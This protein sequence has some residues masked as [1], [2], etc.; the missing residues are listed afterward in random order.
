M[1][2]ILLQRRADFQELR[3][4]HPI[5][6]YKG[7]EIQQSQESLSVVYDFRIVPDIRFTPRVTITQK[8]HALTE[9]QLHNLVF[10]LGMIESISYWKSTC[11]P[12]YL[13]SA[14]ALSDEQVRWWTQL[15]RLGLGEFFYRNDL[16]EEMRGEDLIT[17]S[18]LGTAF[19]RVSEYEV[20]SD[21]ILVGGGKDSALLLALFDKYKNELQRPITPFMLNP[22]PAAKQCTALC[23]FAARAVFATRNI[24]P[25]LL[26]LNKRGYLNGHT[27]FSA[28]LAFLST[29]VASVNKAQYVFVANEA[30]ANQAN[31]D[32]Q[33]LA[34]NH[35]YSKSYDFEA[36]F[37]SY[38]SHYLGAQTQYVSALRPVQDLQIAKLFSAYPHYHPVFRSCNVGQKENRWCGSC[39]KCAFVYLTLS[40]FLTKEQLF[41]LFGADLGSEEKIQQHIEELCGLGD[42]KPFECVGTFEE[43]KAAVFLL[44]KKR[45]ADT[46]VW[47]KKILLKLTERIPDPEELLTQQLSHWN[48]QN[49][50]PAHIQKILRTEISIHG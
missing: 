28:Y 46:P 50:V 15:V 9:A 33:G 22:I 18:S 38:A 35:Q 26:S 31:A 49:F 42:L 12:Q 1:P 32:N 39:S 3:K 16:L 20:D 34:I 8:A 24:D 29:L 25:T 7:F 19:P 5:F 10:H 21:M 40:P 4:R 13:V 36:S 41:M 47:L 48:S 11:S 23:S 44:A 14:G 27:P 30:S 17:M 37:R 45:G 6:E 2:D 43:S